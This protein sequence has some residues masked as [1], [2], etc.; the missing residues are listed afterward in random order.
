MNAGRPFLAVAALA[1]ILVAACGRDDPPTAPG[2]HSLSGHVVLMGHLISPLGALVGDRVV[3]DA[4]GVAVE[5]LYGSRVVARTQTVDGVYRFGGVAPGAYVARS[6]VVGD[7]ADQTRVL[8]L[9]STDLVAGDTIKLIP[10]GDLFPLPNPLAAKGTTV[11][12]D[13]A[14]TQQVAVHVLDLGGVT[15]RVLFEGLLPP[16]THSTYWDG[17]D[18]DSLL[19]PPGQYWVTLEAPGQAP[20]AQ[21]LFTKDP[22]W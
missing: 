11:Y 2:T 22:S 16:G 9:T 6:R 20:R 3:G 4:D 18:G 8:T 21:L 17:L 15:R 10:R 5:L 12:F 7:I 1:A 19:A 13:L 14:D